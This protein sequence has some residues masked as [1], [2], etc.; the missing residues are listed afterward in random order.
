[1]KR[2]FQAS[3][4]AGLIFCGAGCALFGTKKQDI[5]EATLPSWIGRVIMVE[6]GHRFVLVDVGAGSGPAAGTA[7][8]AYREKRRTAQLIVTKESRP[9]YI[10]MEVIE[11]GPALGD[12]V[13][14]DERVVPPVAPT[15]QP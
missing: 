9:P 10:A 15:T 2:V 13:V 1:V 14:A 8:M 12:Q 6:T 7:A 11:G 5:P 3:A 4:A